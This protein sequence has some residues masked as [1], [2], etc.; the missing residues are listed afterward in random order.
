MALPTLQPH[1][2]LGLEKKVKGNIHFLSDDEVVY[3]VGSLVAV[4]N[5]P[6][7]K[8]SYIKLAD[9]GKNLVQINV[10]PNRKVI[11]ISE[12]SERGPMITLW[13]TALFRKRKTI[14]I[15][16][17]RQCKAS[18][19]AH[20]EF[21]YDS[22]Y[23]VAVTGEPDW[24]MYNIRCEKGRIESFARANNLNG[25]GTIEQV[26]CNPNDTNQVALCGNQVLRCV[27]C[28][29]FIWRQ[30]G[31][32]KLDPAHYTSICWLTQDRLIVGSNRGKIMVL[33]TGEV[34]GVYHASDLAYINMKVNL[35]EESGITVSPSFYDTF[36]MDLPPS[37][38][39]FEIRSITLFPG[40]FL[41]GYTNGKVCVYETKSSVRY[42][43]RGFLLIPDRSIDRENEGENEIL[44]KVNFITVNPSGDRLVVS[45]NE[46]QLWTEKILVIDE[47]SGSSV[48]MKPFGYEQHIG[49]IADIA[50]C[51]WKPIALTIGVS[52]RTI[53][54]WN[55]ETI[56]MELMK[57]FEDDIYSVDLHPTGL[58]A[59][60][61]FSDKLRFMTI[62]IDDIIV[63]K[64]FNVRACSKCRFSRLGHLFAAANGSIIQ[65]FSSVTFE[66]LYIL[67]AHN[68]RISGLDWCAND[69]VLASAGVEGALYLWDVVKSQ[70]I[71][72][73]VV[74]TNPATDIRIFNDGTGFFAVGI[75]GHIREVSNAVILKNVPM[76][77][78]TPIDLLILSAL[79]NIM[80][81]TGNNGTIFILPLP[82]MDKPEFTEVTLHKASVIAGVLSFD[83]KYFISGSEAGCVFFWKLINAEERAIQKFEFISCNEILISKQILEDKMEET[84]NLTLRLNELENEHNYQMKQNE[85]LAASKLRDIHEN[86][87]AAIEDLK[88]RNDQMEADHILEINNINNFIMKLKADHADLI[89]N[90]EVT[91]NGK[92][93][94][95]FEKFKTYELKMEQ[96]IKEAYM[97]YEALTKEK[98][99][100]EAAIIEEYTMK[101]NEKI[102]EYNK[103]LD[104]FQNQAI[105]NEKMKADIEED[106][107][108]EILEIKEQQQNKLKEER[109]LNMRL[110]SD[111]S[112]MKK[113]YIVAQKEVD[114][115]K[116]KLFAMEAEQEKYKGFVISL[117]QD[118]NDMKKE[119]QER[120]QT[121]EEKEKRIYMLKNKNQELEKFKFILD[122]KI[123]ELKSEIEPKER[124]ITEQTTQINKMV[125]ELENLQ[126]MILGMDLQLEQYREKLN[127]SNNE[128]KKEMDKN[129]FMK[130]SLQDIRIDIHQASGWI[131]NIPLLQKAV[132]N[133]YCK[134][135]TDK[136]FEVAQQEDTEAKSEFLRQRDFLERAVATLHHQASKN[137]NTLSFDK[138]RL[139]D[140]NAALLEE[141]NQLRRSL[142]S[143][144]EQNR[145]LASLAG[146]SRMT[147][148][149]AQQRVNFATATNQEIHKK[150]KDA[151]EQN[152]KTL[153]AMK[154]EN[155]RLLSKIS[156]KGEMREKGTQS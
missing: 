121:I 88:L 130:K 142:Q 117:E 26:A 133:M 34:R 151:L 112:N 84:K 100:N 56:T 44:T 124:I 128:I 1:M 37:N 15:P 150:Y 145:K 87:C 147:P 72:E 24:T 2:L 69:N 60:M 122:F 152:A 127:A 31:Y 23:I 16:A 113:Q 89:E 111:I 32:N 14:I 110:R 42:K 109:E 108:K 129:R 28:V 156:E 12:R 75:D 119:I 7:K 66:M 138:V 36:G 50:V 92:L 123:K 3:P 13:D 132:R 144:V 71:S 102:G 91:Y 85:S 11:A 120:D 52:D 80:F 103:L 104:D 97:N 73:T 149:Q 82:L 106:A 21:S 39:N 93:L 79:N 54:I 48:F 62:M 76:P 94:N 20:F 51:R 137:T 53:K 64:E 19:F 25:T 139:V 95:E 134:Y 40:G 118:K 55:Y 77:V 136:D 125:R 140:E 47:L 27:G 90:M 81:L 107:D 35:D 83:D 22:K 96:R 74:K 143:E 29:D 43:R 115:F 41:F 30:F 86:Y 98:E 58:Y 4:H 101:L 59:I 8:Q 57:I 116:Q 49:P 148:Q 10:S 131:Q 146:M 9:R 78:T 135:N 105:E 99:E 154:E 46:M 141:T 45:C 153:T 38:E 63:T 5:I 126:K 70:R 155:F 61:G 33:E 68:R 67:K 17:D 18:E 65:V 6:N 114:D